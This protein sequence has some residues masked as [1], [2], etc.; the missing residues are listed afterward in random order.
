MLFLILAPGGSEAGRWRSL[1]LLAGMPL[2]GR[3]VRAALGAARAMGGAGHRVACA[4]GDPVIG[5]VAGAWGAEVVQLTDAAS[6]FGAADPADAVLQALDLLAVGEDAV[7]A[8]ALMRPTAPLAGPEDLARAVRL[9]LASGGVPVMTM[10]SAGRGWAAGIV[11][12]GAALVVA[13]PELRRTRRLPEPEAARPSL[14]PGER[15]IEVRSEDDL[16]YCEHLLA[17]LPQTPIAVGDRIVGGGAPCFVIAEAGVNH[18]GNLGLAHRLV[19]AGADAGADAVKFQTFEPALLASVEAPLAD[20]QKQGVGREGSQQAML[21]RLVLS[22]PAHAELK[23]H[24]EARKVLFLSSPFDERSADFLE[25]LGVPAFKIPSGETVNHPFLAHVARKG[26]PVLMSTGMCDMLEVAAAVDVVR[27]S[28]DPPLALL[29]CVSSYPAQA[30]D[31]NLKAMETLRRA[32]GVPVGWSD[33]TEGIDIACAATALG[34]K[35]VEKHLTLDRGLP[36]PDHRA[37]LEP[38]ELGRLVRSIRRV[39]E[40]LGGGEKAPRPSETPIAA[41][42]RK[43]LHWRVSLGAGAE[44]VAEHLIALRP[45]TGLLPSRVSR[46]VGRRVARSVKAGTMVSDQ[47]L[48]PPR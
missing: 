37:S 46:L 30:G 1:G 29:H 41:V 18:N 22:A 6:G 39:E 38:A 42:A 15:G 43:S 31:S 10:A 21:E 8:L 40:S 44:V 27:G 3:A 24:A 2:V 11:P 47:D 12:N 14:I 32:F 35:L 4:A 9:F 23:A 20:Y 25:R 36:G 5:A 33:H 13:V 34:A 28:G 17:R 45:G 19:D 7:S 26:R 48:E 16:A